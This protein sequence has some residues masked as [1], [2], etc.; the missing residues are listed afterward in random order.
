LAVVGPAISVGPNLRQK[1]ISQGWKAFLYGLEQKE[2]IRYGQGHLNCRKFTKPSYSNV[3]SR[4]RR[5]VA[6][7]ITL[8]QCVTEACESIS[9]D[10]ALPKSDFLGAGDF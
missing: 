10:K 7:V 1:R 2:A 8:A 3:T 5:D 9:V 4:N 6:S